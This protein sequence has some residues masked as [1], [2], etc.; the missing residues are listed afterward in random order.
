[1][2]HNNTSRQVYTDFT[3]SLLQDTDDWK[4][5][6]AEDVSIH[7]PLAHFSGIE[8]CIAIHEEFYET[9]ERRVIHELIEHE[10]EIITQ[11]SITIETQNKRSVTLDMSEWYTIRAGKIE[12][13]IVYFDASI[14]KSND[15][16]R[17]DEYKQ[18]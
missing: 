3:T 10:N 7:G 14:L 12:D 16:N 9:V 11:V 8:H 18:Y 2:V 4:H 13:I 6:I 1:M 5:M 17:Y 15:K